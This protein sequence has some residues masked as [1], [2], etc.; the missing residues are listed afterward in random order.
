LAATAPAERAAF[1]QQVEPV[2]GHAIE[3][4]FPQLGPGGNLKKSKLPPTPL[5]D[6]TSRQ[7]LRAE[8]AAYQEQAQAQAAAQLS[9]KTHEATASD[10]T[11]VEWVLASTSPSP[12]PTAASHADRPSPA[13]SAKS[14]S[15][16]IERE[17]AKAGASTRPTTGVVSPKTQDATA[18]N[19]TLSEPSAAIDYNLP[20]DFNLRFD[21]FAAAIGVLNQQEQDLL[22]DQ[23]LRATTPR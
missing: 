19:A 20:I 8:I 21:D 17:T 22:W 5:A 18:G 13:A 11:P 6:E 2:C 7:A 12:Q 15:K 9:P 14:K 1:Y 4:C 23:R 10:A 3:Y 16:P